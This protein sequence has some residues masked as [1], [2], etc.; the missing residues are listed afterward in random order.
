MTDPILED[1]QNGNPTVDEEELRRQSEIESA[2][3]Q[4][5]MDEAAALELPNPAQPAAGNQPQQPQQPTGSNTEKEEKEVPVE[6]SKEETEQPEEKKEP[7]P[8]D[9]LYTPRGFIEQVFAAPTGALDFG[10]DIINM[11]PG[12][13]A[14]KLPKFHSGLAQST[15]EIFSVVAPTIGLTK[16][17]TGGASVGA[18]RIGFTAPSL[19]RFLADPFVKWLGTTSMAAGTGAAVDY[20]SSTS[21]EGDNLTGTLKKTWPKT[22]GWIPDDIATLDDDSPDM[23]RSKTVTEGIGIGVFSDLFIGSA[24][25]LQALRGVDE[26]TKWVPESE[27]AGKYFETLNKGKKVTEEVATTPPKT[28]ELSLV[29]RLRGKTTPEEELVLT[30]EDGAKKRS[31][32]LDKI[33]EDTF[34]RTQSL[35]EPTLGVHDMF[36]HT[37]S[38]V[39]TTDSKG[40]VGA[41]ADQA[42]I[43]S[44]ADTVHGRV[45]SV[46]SESTM[47]RITNGDADVEDVVKA[48][49]KNLQDA[50]EFGYK[51]PSGKYLSYKQ[52]MASADKLAETIYQMPMDDMKLAI[53][54]MQTIDPETGT[55]VFRSEGAQT[56]KKLMEMTSEDMKVIGKGGEMA[57][58]RANALVQ[59]SMAGQ[60]SDLAMGARLMEGSSAVPRA[61]DLM[62]DRMQFMMIQ[63]GLNG[64]VKGRALAMLKNPQ[65]MAK[66]DPEQL[67]EAKQK[68]VA[69]AAV[70]ASTMRALLKENP[71]MLDPIRLAYELTDGE[72]NTVTKLNNYVRQSTSAL[73]KALIDPQPDI[74]NI[75]VQGHF[76]TIYNSILSALGTPIKAG[77]SSVVLLGERPLA[78]G[79]AGLGGLVRPGTRGTSA[80]VL[81]RAWFGYS[82]LLGGLQKSIPYMNEI[83]RRSA[84]V[85]DVVNYVGREGSYLRNQRQLE[86]LNSVA[87][88][89]AANGEFGPKAALAQF[90][91]LEDIAQ[92]PKLRFGQRA[93]MALDGFT[94]SMIGY[95]ESRMR[96]WDKYTVDGTYSIDRESLAAMA[97]DVYEDMFDPATNIIRDSAVRRAGGEIAMNLDSK[98]VNGVTELIRRFPMLKPFML[99]P[100]TTVNMMQFS[101]S[102]NPV[103]M[104]I[105]KVNKFERP[106]NKMDGPE[107]EK[108]LTEYGEK[109]DGD[110]EMVYETLRAEMKGRKAI[111]AMAV[112]TTSGMFL[113]GRI[114]GNGL[115]D[116]QKQQLRR[117]AGWKPRTAQG[118]DGKWYSYEW[119]GPLADWVSLTS[120]IG[121]NLIEGSLTEMDANELFSMMGFIISANLTDK[122]FIAGLEPLFD[123]TSGNAGAINRWTSAYMSG[124]LPLSSMRGEISRLLTPQLKEV[125]NNFFELM[126]NRNP[127]FKGSLPD[128]Y[129]WIDGGVV[130]IP[131]NPMTRIMNVY[132]PWKVSDSISDEKQFLID[133]EY[134][135]RPAVNKDRNGI[136]YTNE[137]RSLIL[138]K[139]GEQG[140]FKEAIK[141]VMQTQDAKQ[142]RKDFRQAQKDGLQPRLEQFKNI[143]RQLDIALRESVAQAASDLP[144]GVRQEIQQKGYQRDVVEA[145]TQ[146]GD[147]E[148]AKRYLDTV[149]QKYSY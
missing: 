42:R 5:D 125:E 44:N 2:A 19:G 8:F 24:K 9:S 104:F 11:I 26:A 64:Y 110:V 145:Y 124:Q 92:H 60:I 139:M 25:V 41:A 111:G 76:A 140:Y 78:T 43:A 117:E 146:R 55:R 95:A 108:V 38:G 94:N 138:S 113:T 100:K 72:I 96:A 29:D 137:E 28:K 88:A 45:G 7:K 115:Y 66:F 123:M 30:L 86:L 130:G 65:G 46:V 4:Q 80:K 135:G 47:L 53:K 48:L 102:H 129:D 70:T 33:G 121:D 23:K 97:E 56:V 77:V 74:P 112:A 98:A 114:H 54:A 149:K 75:F 27:K 18:A 127:G 148:G 133:I 40:I 52:I 132:T 90:E 12:V 61:T 73:Q 68:I 81:K 84:N 144:D 118:L 35:D 99:F 13:N 6:G 119:L 126:A 107:V 134:D 109:M 63:N 103:G 15:R 1:I 131:D 32:E 34:N 101:G 85:D 51:T 37:E 147:L 3:I 83:F 10:V 143:H 106:F 58:V 122:S 62:I 69:N 116:R 87:D 136:K 93:M 71:A 21:K 141:R 50:D 89:K 16:L 91:M 142:F 67:K 57:E 79:L 22:F 36:D 128:R 105:D 39:R 82:N 120:D 14:P 49:A 17:G 31:D 20:T 59:A